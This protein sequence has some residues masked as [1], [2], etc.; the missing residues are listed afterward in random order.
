M[1]PGCK[2]Q[3][4]C[5]YAFGACSEEPELLEV[6]DGRTTRC[7]L[8]D[9]ANGARLDA[10]LAEPHYGASIDTT[11]PQRAARPHVEGA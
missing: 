8:Q 1:P 2:F 9:P 4:R 10:Y 6:N 7:W 3:P 5:P 11:A